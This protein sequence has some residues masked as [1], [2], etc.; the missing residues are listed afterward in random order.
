MRRTALA[1]TTALALAFGAA[2]AQA[3]LLEMVGGNAFTTP[4][5]NNFLSG[6]VG[7][8]NDL[9]VP[10]SVNTTAGN[11]ILTFTYLYR[12]SGFT[13]NRF[14]AGPNGDQFIS[15]QRASM[16]V[17]GPFPTFEYTQ[18]SAGLIDF[19]FI[20]EIQPLVENKNGDPS[21]PG[22]TLGSCRPRFWE[23]GFFATVNQPTPRSEANPVAS[24]AK[25]DVIWLAFDDGGAK[26]D[27]HD[28]LIIRISARLAPTLVPEPAALALLGA[29]LLG[30]G[31]ARRARRKG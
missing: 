14:L 19:S 31:L 4:G 17:G 2:S 1:C 24:G 12:E 21:V 26:D 29:G 7:R 9:G 23:Y 22:C 15:S 16:A 5:V 10:L 28:D 27:N 6:W 25:G 8:L 20:S 18:G 30:L 11:V 3:G 13:R